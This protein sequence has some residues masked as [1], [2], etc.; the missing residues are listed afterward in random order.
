MTFRD[1]P[2]FGQELIWSWPVGGV[3]VQAVVIAPYQAVL[4]WKFFAIGSSK[5]ESRIALACRSDNREQA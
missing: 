3:S 2:P 5:V 4:G 1:Q